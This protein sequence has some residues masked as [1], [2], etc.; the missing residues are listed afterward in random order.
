MNLDRFKLRKLDP[1]QLFMN[2]IAE[3]LSHI[4]SKSRYIIVIDALNECY[5]NYRE[6][7]IRIIRD[8]WAENTPEWLG[9]IV[10]ASTG[11]YAIKRLRRAKVWCSVRLFLAY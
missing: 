9:L 10:S 1:Q 11:T 8:L 6:Q 4:K 5:K 2:L 7:I 3:P